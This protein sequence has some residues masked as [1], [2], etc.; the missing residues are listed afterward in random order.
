MLQMHD[1]KDWNLRLTAGIDEPQ[2]GTKFVAPTPPQKWTI[3]TR[4]LFADFGER[5]ITGIALTV[6]GQ[7]PGH[8]DHIYFARSIEELDGIDAT[9]SSDTPPQLKPEDLDRLW[10]NLASDDA[11]KTYAAVWNLAASPA[12]SVP[13]LRKTLLWPRSPEARDLIDRWIIELEAD[14]FRVRDKAFQNL[15]QHV[16]AAVEQLKK[17]L[18]D[19]PPESQIRIQELL[20][21]AYSGGQNSLRTQQAMRLLK[22]LRTPEATAVLE[23]LSKIAPAR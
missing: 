18:P 3:V 2:W 4:D 21:L 7:Q 20:K 5:T 11:A 1:L 16:E 22:H 12:Q 15:E 19:A 13:F 8:F 9:I 6:F 14:E 23:E 10:S 17:N